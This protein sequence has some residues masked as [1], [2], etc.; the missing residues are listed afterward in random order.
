MS[1]EN[2]TI[3]SQRYSHNPT[4]LAILTGMVVI[5]LYGLYAVTAFFPP[6]GLLLFL[7][8]T[9]FALFWKKRDLLL[10]IYLLSILLQNQFIA[11]STPFLTGNKFNFT[12]LHGLNF[13]IP[14]FLF[15]Y[16]FILY[17]KIKKQMVT[18]IVILLG[19]LTILGIYFLFGLSVYGLAPSL[20]YLRLF[21]IPFIMFLNGV[22]IARFS[23]ESSLR[24]V[25][26]FVLVLVTSIGIV[27]FLFPRP[28]TT[29]LNDFSYFHLKS[30]FETTDDLLQNYRTSF[31]N[32]AA[33]PEVNRVSSLIKSIISYGYVVVIISIYLFYHNRKPLMF[34]FIIISLL[35]VGSKGAILLLFLCIFFYILKI[36]LRFSLGLSLLLF[37][38]MWVFFIYIGYRAE[39]EHLI[40][41]VSGLSYIPSMGNG[42]GFAGNLSDVQLTSWNGYPLPDLGYWTRFQNG[43]ESVFGV[44]FSSLGFASLIFIVLALIFILHIYKT[45]EQRNIEVAILIILLFFQGIFQEEAFSP[46]A[47][48]LVMFLGGFYYC[49]ELDEKRES[50]E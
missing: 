9:F 7:A 27:Q 38:I 24:T 34:L 30:G 29:L 8:F 33:L 3:E 2:Y 22:L 5:V 16:F 23:N 32:L 17:T 49:R 28:L 12:L 6:L 44:L 11:Y 18:P 48:G 15:I 31:L 21:S 36:R 40:G 13:V 25:L 41:F 39:N 19:L 35:T 4:S 20:S 10:I 47:Y 50:A 14:F 26:A 42:L 43:S 37:S 45:I 46:Y 1:I